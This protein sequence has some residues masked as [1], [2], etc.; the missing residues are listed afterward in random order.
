MAAWADEISCGKGLD[1]LIDI[2]IRLKKQNICK[3][4]GEMYATH[5]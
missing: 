4:G 2:M 3:V 1:R 5:F